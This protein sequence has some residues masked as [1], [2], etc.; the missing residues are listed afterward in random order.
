MIVMRRKRKRKVKIDM[1]LMM[2]KTEILSLNGAI[3]H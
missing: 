2:L 1:D 3:R